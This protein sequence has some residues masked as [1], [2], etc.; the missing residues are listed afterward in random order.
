ME[1]RQFDID[2]A[3][4][5]PRL[6][7]HLEVN[8]THVVHEGDLVPAEYVF[9]TSRPFAKRAQ[10]D[11]WAVPLFTRFDGLLTVAEVFEAARAED[12]LPPE[13]GLENFILL[14]KRS[15]EA[16]FLILPEEDLGLTLPWAV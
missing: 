10:F 6:A 5:K 1:A 13:L 4:T 3:Q 2:L 12:D 14:V 15:I 11:P 16:G 8:V 9:S 7:P